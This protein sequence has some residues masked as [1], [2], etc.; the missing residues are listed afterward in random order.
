MRGPIHRGRVRYIGLVAAAGLVATTAMS[1]EPATAAPLSAAPAKSRAAAGA[2]RAG[3]YIVSFAD[4]PLATYDGSKAASL[5][6][7]PPPAGS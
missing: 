5:P 7:A 1:T 3:R 6:P 2:Y 4:D